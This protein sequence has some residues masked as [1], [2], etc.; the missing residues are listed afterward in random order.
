MLAYNQSP[1]RTT[2][3]SP[4][5]VVHGQN[6]LRPLDLTPFHPRESL[7][8]KA[9]KRVRE[10]QEF[11]KRIQQKIKKTN[12]YYQSQA[13][14]HSKQALFQ[15]GDLVRVHLVKERFPSKWKSKL[16][17]LADGPLEVLEKI[18][19]AYKIVLPGDY[20]AS[21]TF[22]VADLKPYFED[23]KLENLREK[24]FLGR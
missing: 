5:K 8:T 19:N 2:K 16:I 23:D 1:N 4:F 3:E 7:S 10:I 6:P 21:Y 17:P 14:K 11:H 20:G 12:E 18:N 24:L 13:N 9:S 22:N 15:P